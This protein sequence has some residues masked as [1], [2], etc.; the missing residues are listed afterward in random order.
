[1]SGR[2]PSKLK[3]FVAVSSSVSI[4]AAEIVDHPL[5]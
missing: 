2:F 5:A 4:T 1:V 3:I